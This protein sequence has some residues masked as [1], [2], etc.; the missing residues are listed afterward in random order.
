VYSIRQEI[1]MTVQTLHI[2]GKEF[3]LIPMRDFKV[4]QRRATS[5]KLPKLPEPLAN[6]N[7][8]AA[9]TIRVIYARRLTQERE[10][11]GLSQSELARRAGVCIETINRL[12]KGKHSPDTSTLTKITKALRAAGVKS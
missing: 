7:Y 2:S 4:L 6:G 10:A 3:A 9:E 11:A 5:Q 1:D 8:L 12:E